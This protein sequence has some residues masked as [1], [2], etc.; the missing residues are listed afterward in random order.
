MGIVLLLALVSSLGLSPSPLSSQII[1]STP[2][3]LKVYFASEEALNYLIEFDIWEINREE[4]YVIIP[5]RN[6]LK[7]TLELN[8]YVVSTVEDPS[9]F[10][11]EAAPQ[12]F[13][14]GYIGV[15]EMEA[16]LI[17]TS[18]AYPD[19]TTLITYGQSHCLVQAGCTLPNGNLLNGHPLYALRITN[20]TLGNPSQI[21][22]GMSLTQT[23][24]ISGSKP[25]FLL[26]AGIHAREVATTDL[27]MRFIAHLTKKYQK[28]PD[29]TWLIDQH[30]IWILPLANPDGYELIEQGTEDGVLYYQRK[31]VNQASC[32]VWP[33]ESNFQFGVDLN[34][35]HSYSWG[36]TGSSGSPCNTTYRGTAPASEPEVASLEALFLDLFADQRGEARTDAAPIDTSGLLITMHSYGDLILWP[37]G[38]DGDPII[39]PN[40]ADLGAIANR[41]AE[42]NG[43]LACQASTCLYPAAGATDDFVYGELGVPSFTYEIGDQ[44]FP[45]YD[46]VES[47]LWEPNLPSFIHSA[48]IA[49]A[50]YHLSRGPDINAISYTLESESVTITAS[51]SDLLSGGANIAKVELSVGQPFTASISS[52]SLD[53]SVRI[54]M[55]AVDGNFDNSVESIVSPSIPETDLLLSGPTAIYL[56]GVDSDGFTGPIYAIFVERPIQYIQ[57]LPITGTN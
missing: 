57:Y 7:A 26:M 20:E 24:I 14:N 55:A 8:G 48:K 10:S 42:Y 54:P 11:L 6:N 35:N 46:S 37:W 52:D 50:P 2:P 23:E 39:A 53:E 51:A 56:R 22:N 5:N 12:A 21:S 47:E 49:A 18:L 27:A 33:P 9:L 28:D 38:D 31:N 30:E 40:H 29:V 1:E 4:N 17:S 16:T 44:F 15:L 19:I 32:S 41:L 36:G 43:Y 34:R 13:L 3:L 45:P 25:I